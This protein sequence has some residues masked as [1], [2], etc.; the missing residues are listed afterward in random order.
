MILD[1]QTL[2]RARDLAAEIG[3]ARNTLWRWTAEKPALRA[4]LFRPGWYSVQ[5]LRE[6][7]IVTTPEP[8]TSP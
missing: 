4:C 8:S 7:G 3:I 6:A 2:I 1:Q 5:K